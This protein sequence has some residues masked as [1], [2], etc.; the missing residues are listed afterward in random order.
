[1]NVP[2]LRIDTSIEDTEE[3]IINAIEFEK[4]ILFYF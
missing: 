1:M 3:T 4:A 2:T